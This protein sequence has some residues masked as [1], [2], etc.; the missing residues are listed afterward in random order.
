MKSIKNILLIILIALLLLTTSCNTTV[1]KSSLE[2]GEKQSPEINKVDKT[3]E[4]I[5]NDKSYKYREN[6]IDLIDKGKI[7]QIKVAD[8]SLID[9]ISIDISLNNERMILKDLDKIKVGISVQKIYE[10]VFTDVVK[11]NNSR[12][13]W[14]INLKDGE[15]EEN[16]NL[17]LLSNTD[18]LTSDEKKLLTNKKESKILRFDI[19]VDEGSPIRIYNH[20]L[21]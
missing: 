19:F 12:K 3:S 21:D 13:Y 9:D 20:F 17:N 16:Y 2:K 4:K 7:F 6:L 11:F 18:L 10:E 1:E 15:I 14:E 8:N 5:E